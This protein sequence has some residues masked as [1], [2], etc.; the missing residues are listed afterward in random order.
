M[1]GMIHLSERPIKRVAAIHDLS[2]FGKS[3]LTVVIPVLSSMNIQV[4][5]IPTA[6]LSTQ[7]DGFENYVFTDLTDHMKAS[8]NHWKKLNL[9]FDAIYSGFLGS[10]KQIDI[11][12]DFINYFKKNEETLVVVDPVMGDYGQLYSSITKNLVEEMKKLIIKADVIIPNYTEACLLLEENYT[13]LVEESKLKEWMR[14]LSEKGPKIVIIT[15]IPNKD[16]S[17]TGV[18]AYNKED[19]KFWKITNEYIKASYPGTGDAFASVITGSLLKK[20]SLSTAI[21]KATYF[22][23]TCLKASCGYNYPPREGILL[24]KVL[25]TLSEPT[26]IQCHEI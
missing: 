2:G 7:T 19:G 22:V 25:E 3:S 12:I 4:C 11:V 17:K 14:K 21:S 5:P 6:V 16:K 13:E 8:I 24:E 1:K 9:S 23:T 26:P 15:S 18:I 20:D 10:E